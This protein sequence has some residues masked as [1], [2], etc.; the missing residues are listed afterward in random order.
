MSSLERDARRERAGRNE[1]LFREVN[2]RVEEIANSFGADTNTIRF[3]CEC[4]GTDCAE[5]IQMTVNEYEALRSVPERFAIADG[6]QIPDVE[7]T[8][9]KSTRYVIVEKIGAGEEVAKDLDP[10]AAGRRG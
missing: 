1:S 5:T 3:I 6:H 4:A 9:E 10:R 8:V 2:E 7:R